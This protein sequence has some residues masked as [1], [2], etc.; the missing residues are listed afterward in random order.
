MNKWRVR[1][2][3]FVDGRHDLS[4]STVWDMFEEC[5]DSPKVQAN[6]LGISCGHLYELAVLACEKLN[7]RN[8]RRVYWR[9]MFNLEKERGPQ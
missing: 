2:W 1:G 5:E 9:Q 4:I 3:R 7:I 6:R 8:R